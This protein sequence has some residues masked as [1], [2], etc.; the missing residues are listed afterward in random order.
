MKPLSS[1]V[2]VSIDAVAIKEM[3]GG[4]YANN[5]N[6]PVVFHEILRPGGRSAVDDDDEFVGSVLRDANPFDREDSP[7]S[8]DYYL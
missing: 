8:E 6:P 3:D 4:T 7:W 2:T 1:L 5:S